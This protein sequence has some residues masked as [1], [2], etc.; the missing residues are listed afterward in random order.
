MKKSLALILS[1]IMLI[2][3]VPVFVFAENSE[4][5]HESYIWVYKGAQSDY[6]CTK[7]SGYRYKVCANPDCGEKLSEEEIVPVQLNHYYV[8]I[9][10]DAPCK[11]DDP[12]Y[13]PYIYYECSICGFELKV[14]RTDAGHI[15]GDNVIYTKCF[16]GENP[17]ETGKYIRECKRCQQKDIISITNHSYM[18]IDGK[19][20]TCYKEGKTAS[21]RCQ[22]C[23]T[24][25]PVEVIPVLEHIDANSDNKCDLCSGALL[26]E[27]VFCSCLCH[28]EMGIIKNFLLPILQFIWKLLKMEVCQCGI[29]HA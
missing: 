6:D 5:S 16:E 7:E 2:S 18:P 13:V 3:A 1:L 29:V 11:K 12:D 9:K 14:E 24:S 17:H 8:E 21:R 10:K 23:L 20:A 28:S 25:S 15:W 27:G 19:A 4:C 26:E 22:T